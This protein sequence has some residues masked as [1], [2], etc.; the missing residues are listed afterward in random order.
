MALSACGSPDGGLRGGIPPAPDPAPVDGIQLLSVP[1]NNR[2]ANVRAI[3]RALGY[4]DTRLSPLDGDIDGDID[5]DIERH[6]SDNDGDER[7]AA[8]A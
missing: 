2:I 4:D 5:R 6:L 8:V 3:L 7:F 1:T